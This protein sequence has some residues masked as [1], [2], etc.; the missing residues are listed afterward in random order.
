M[1]D[2][3]KQ[4]Y[5]IIIMITLALITAGL[6]WV[7]YL[8]VYYL[9]YIGW[10]WAI[11]IASIP[12]LL[13]IICMLG[14][15]FIAIL[16]FGEKEEV[17]DENIYNIS[18][19]CSESMGT[20]DMLIKSLELYLKEPEKIVNGICEW[21]VFNTMDDGYRIFNGCVQDIDEGKIT[22]M[23]KKLDIDGEICPYCGRKI[24]VVENE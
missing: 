20:P 1:K 6:W 23:M 10:G 7:A 9:H 8:A 17:E 15:V 13:G 2:H 5:I 21:E 4:L 11:I 22:S 12:A 18:K 16:W 14:I 19:E 3:I 24:K